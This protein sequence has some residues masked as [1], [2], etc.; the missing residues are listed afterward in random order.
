VIDL[1]QLARISAE[2]HGT[3]LKPDEV[4]EWMIPNVVV[5]CDACNGEVDSSKGD[6]CECGNTGFDWSDTADIQATL[7][8]LSKSVGSQKD[9]S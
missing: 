9:A 7:R 1:K 2:D 5:L 3:P 4:N 8:A 6:E